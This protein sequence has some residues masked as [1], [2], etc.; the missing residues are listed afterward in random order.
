MSDQQ[1]TVTNLDPRHLQ[2]HL[3]FKLGK[4]TYAIPLLTV[5]EVIGMPE[6]TPVPFTPGY[7]LG[8]MNL[9][10]QVISVVDLRLKLNLKQ[11]GANP[12]TAVIICDLG[13]TSLG[14]VVDSIDAVISP[15]AQ[16]I[17]DK[18][19]IHSQQNTDYIT[20]V[21]QR[22]KQMT[23]F[24]DIAGL[25]SPQDRAAMSKASGGKAA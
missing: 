15:V 14:V 16:E 21:F 22:D 18:P 7:F 2:R 19:E 24:I 17:S 8:I 1:A 12:E 10:G 20:V 11:Q 4:E 23:L 5:R 6:I 25:L 9:R 3:S 13:S